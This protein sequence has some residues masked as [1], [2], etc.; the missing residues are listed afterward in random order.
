MQK[1]HN[2]NVIEACYNKEFPHRP[3]DNFYLPSYSL[4]VLSGTLIQL[5]LAGGL[6]ECERCIKQGTRHYNIALKKNR[7]LFQMTQIVM[8]YMLAIQVSIFH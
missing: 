1:S 6:L 2:I 8:K 7:T 5:L 3:K 4:V